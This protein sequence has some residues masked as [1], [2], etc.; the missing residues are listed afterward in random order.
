MTDLSIDWVVDDA[1]FAALADEWEA[2][3]EQRA[4]PFVRH[5]WFSSWWHAFG[6]GRSLRVCIARRE[7]RLVGALPLYLWS[8]R[9]HGLANEHTPLF[10]ALGGL[11]ELEALVEAAA[12]ASNSLEI[13]AVAADDPLVPIAEQVARRH[14]AVALREPHLVSPIVV[15][16]GSYDDYL[17][18]IPKSLRKDTVRRRRKLEAEQS[19]DLV[20]LVSPADVDAEL[21]AGFAVEARSWKGRRGTAIVSN[22]ATERFYRELGRV[23]AASGRLRLSQLLADGRG[24]AFDFCL[25]DGGRLWSL[26]FGFDEAFGRYGPGNVLTLAELERCYEVGLEAFE[27]LGDAEPWKSRFADDARELV[28]VRIYRRRPVPLARYAYRRALR[29]AARSVY[30]RAIAPKLNGRSRSRSR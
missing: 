19:V 1:S 26:K 15:L 7:G 5:A 18:R 2:L 4:V 20:L 11:R 17:R 12:G 29:P 22:G 16:D 24:I 6:D 8:G 30:R 9:L 3:A 14:G 28:N 27:L 10:G 25:V 13:P 21:T 23:F